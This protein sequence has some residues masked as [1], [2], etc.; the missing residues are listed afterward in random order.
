[1]DRVKLRKRVLIVWLV[2]E[3]N[4]IGFNV[5]KDNFILVLVKIYN[6]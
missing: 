6:S 4:I 3:D 1:M 2:F 5:L